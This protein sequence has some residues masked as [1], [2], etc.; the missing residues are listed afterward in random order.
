MPIEL[1][2]EVN[3][4]DDEFCYLHDMRQ[5]R[6]FQVVGYYGSKPTAAKCGEFRSSL[7]LDGEGRFRRCT[8]CHKAE[9]KVKD[10]IHELERSEQLVADQA[11]AMAE[12]TEENTELRNLPEDECM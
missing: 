10:A 11:A 3:P 6:N 1:L 2:V 12:L 7:A 9:D 8:D 5:C 4:P